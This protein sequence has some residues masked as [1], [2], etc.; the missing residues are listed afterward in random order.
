MADLP[1]PGPG[2][3]V[4]YSYL[5]SSEAQRG[6]VEGRK[7]RPCAIVVALTDPAS[8]GRSPR[9]VVVPITHL[10]PRVPTVA[11]EI[12][13]RVKAHLGLDGERSWIVV[14]E[15]N[16]FAWPGFDLRPIRRGETQVHYGWLPPRLF[17]RVIAP[18]VSSTPPPHANRS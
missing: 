15:F 1:K 7:D 14:N 2:L 16:V 4:S 17:D 3:V 10:E 18:A 9:V 5:W 11:V 12:P 13:A 6:H 8:T